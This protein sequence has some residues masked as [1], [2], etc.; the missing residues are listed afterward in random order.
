[1]IGIF[2]VSTRADRFMAISLSRLEPDLATADYGNP[3]LLE[4]AFLAP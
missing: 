1:V 4:A 2:S 3:G